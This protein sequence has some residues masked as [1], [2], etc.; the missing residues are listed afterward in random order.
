MSCYFFS[1]IEIFDY[2]IPMV[3][4]AI[5]LNR[6]TSRNPV[7][8]DMLVELKQNYGSKSKR[9]GAVIYL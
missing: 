4:E 2:F 3:L 6:I 5:R 7:M 9:V 1:S 8:F